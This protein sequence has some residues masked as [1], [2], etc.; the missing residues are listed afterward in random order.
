M[1]GLMILEGER[2]VCLNKFIIWIYLSIKTSCTH[3]GVAQRPNCVNTFN[4]S[5]LAHTKQSGG[6]FMYC[7]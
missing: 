1:R 2:V 4:Q 5:S 6:H 3:V 7:V